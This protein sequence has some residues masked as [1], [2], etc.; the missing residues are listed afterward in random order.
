[1]LKTVVSAGSL[2]AKQHKDVVGLQGTLGVTTVHVYENDAAAAALYSGIAW[3]QAMCQQMHKLSG[4]VWK[5]EAKQQGAQGYAY[6]QS[7]TLC[8]AFAVHD[9]QETCWSQQRCQLMQGFRLK[10]LQVRQVQRARQATCRQMQV[11]SCAC[12]I[13]FLD[14]LSK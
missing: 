1:M 4:H 9:A 6:K 5:H 7:T 3:W 2:E 11:G 8:Q 12:N 13:A 14:V 10:V